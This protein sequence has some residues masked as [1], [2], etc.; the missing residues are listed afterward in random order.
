M[1][2][3][4]ISINDIKDINADRA[5]ESGK[6]KTQY[7]LELNKGNQTFTLKP[8]L[9]P[10]QDKY[11]ILK[12]SPN[13]LEIL[14]TNMTVETKETYWNVFS[15][16]LFIFEHSL[17]RLDNKQIETLITESQSGRTHKLQYGFMVREPS[18]F[19]TLL[20]LYETTT[21]FSIYYSEISGVKP[22]DVPSLIILN[23]M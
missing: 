17:L 16:G 23:K 20:D 11:C 12:S 14:K 6:H 15:G 5:K 22:T 9:P 10:K 18:I 19:R 2:G 21:K 4:N 3:Q 7:I 8:V 1:E 13:G